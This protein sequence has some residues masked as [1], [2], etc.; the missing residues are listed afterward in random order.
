M[1]FLRNILEGNTVSS[2]S[3]ICV[4][5]YCLFASY[6][7]HGSRVFCWSPR[8]VGFWE[9]RDVGFHGCFERFGLLGRC[10][11]TSTDGGP[12]DLSNHGGG[13]PI[14]SCFFTG[15]DWCTN[16]GSRFMY[17]CR[18]EGGLQVAEWKN[19]PKLSFPSSFTENSSGMYPHDFTCIYRSCSCYQ[20]FG[21]SWPIKCDVSHLCLW[22][23]EAKC[24]G[25]IDGAY[26]RHTTTSRNNIKGAMVPLSKPS[27]LGTGG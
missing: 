2:I 21:S 26:E 18:W 1:L 12:L 8:W 13:G 11:S 25:K 5:V 3:S 15:R 23:P 9:L 6:S 16:D 19:E 4:L 10:C 24:C 20:V 27:C 22:N 14:W 17:W 7:Y